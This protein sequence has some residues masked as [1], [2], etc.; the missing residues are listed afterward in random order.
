ML[1]T[2]QEEKQVSRILKKIKGIK[3]IDSSYQHFGSSS[4]KYH[5]NVPTSEEAVSTFEKEKKIILPRSYR[6]F[7]THISNGGPG[8]AYGFF[9][10]EKIYCESDITKNN[11]LFPFMS[12][13]EMD[14]LENMN[15]ESGDMIFQGLLQIGTEGCSYDMALVVTGEY[16]GRIIRTDY[17]LGHTFT[18][19]YD[20]QFLDWYERWV[21]A[22]YNDIRPSSVLFSVPGDEIELQQLYQQ[23]KEPIYQQDILRTFSIFPKLLKKDKEF[24]R[25]YCN[26]TYR[27]FICK[28]SLL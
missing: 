22:F 19:I 25:K 17:D 10:L 2:K 1:L 9:P 18:F 21:D 13:E 4:H 7:L 11:P 27:Y 23:V 24:F 3:A 8:V 12:D 16:R 6:I 15:E 20:L 14:A 5:W 28:T 26:N